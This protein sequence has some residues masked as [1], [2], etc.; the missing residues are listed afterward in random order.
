MRRGVLTAVASS[1]VGQ[2]LATIRRSKDILILSHNNPDPDALASASALRWM[3]QQMLGKTPTIGL[4]GI[5]GRAEN[6]ALVERLGAPLVKMDSFPSGFGGGVILVD[7]QPRRANN[8]LPPDL[9]PIAVIDHHPDGGEVRAVPF[10]DLRESYGATATIVTDYLEEAELTIDPRVATGLFY[11][12]SS[13]TQHLGRDTMSRD[14]AACQFLYPYVSKRLLG[15]IQHPPLPREHFELIG[16]AVRSALLYEDTVAAVLESVPY[17]DAV[18]EIADFLARL[19]KAEWSIVLALKECELYVSV[20]ANRHDA[21][22]GE[23]LSSILPSGA[24]GGHGMIAGGKVTA[25]ERGWR[26]QAARIIR[27]FLTAIGRSGVPG[28]RLI[29]QR[30]ARAVRRTAR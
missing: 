14:I 16:M 20:R 26:S 18:A 15:E 27:D 3:I 29:G 9:T 13:E 11:G 19:E 1:K 28:Q 17:P 8:F 30:V 5:V 7:T 10:V 21:R 24:A 22:A 2:F 25:S 6:R 23:I 12:I 4:A